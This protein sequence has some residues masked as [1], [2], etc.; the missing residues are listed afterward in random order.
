[1]VFQNAYA[2]INETPA[3]RGFI[4]QV[5]VEGLL[6]RSPLRAEKTHHV[7]FGRYDLYGAIR[8]QHTGTV[9]S[10]RLAT[11]VNSQWK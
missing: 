4:S 3:E 1:M 7:H 9:S 10:V 8:H 2:N 5:F 6:C 11:Q